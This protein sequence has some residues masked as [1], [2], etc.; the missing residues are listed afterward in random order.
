MTQIPANLLVPGQYEEIDN[1]LA[2][3]Q[4]DIK[5][6]LIMAYK[7]AAAPALAGKPVQVLTK[8]RAAELCGHGSP[9]AIMA[10]AFLSGNKTEESWILP[11]AE[12]EAGTKWQM[13]FTV[14]ASG[15]GNGSA[16]ITINGK[17]LAAAISAGTTAAQ[18]A[19]AIVARINSEENCPVEAA[20]DEGVVTVSSLVKGVWGNQNAVSITP[21]AAGVTITP[22]EA[23]PG[24]GVADL[25]SLFP[26]L[27]GIRYNY[28]LSDFADFANIAALASELESR[29]S[30]TRQI[31]GRAFIALSGPAGSA[32]EE[33]SVI[34][35][36]EAV[37]SPH[38]VL[39]PRLDNA[40]LPGEWAARFAAP[41]IRRLAD[42]PAANTYD[43]QAGGL[44]AEAEIDFDTRQK[45]LEAGI[46]T[47]RLDPVGNVLIER[48]VTSYTE[49][50]DGG[51]DTSYLDVQVAETVD[52]VRTY[53]NAEAKKRFKSWKLASTEE[54]FG[55]GSKVMSP[56]VFRSFLADL[57]QT[58]FIQEKQWC[59]NF[60]AY[61]DSILVEVMAGNKTRLQ[62]QH[63]PVLIGQFL[64]GAGLLQ[65]S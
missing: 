54:N 32:T 42:D 22:G 19:A 14:A 30:A 24:T 65:F 59:Q 48:L 61:K 64:I 62:Y 3:A 53:I 35:Q 28:F 23:T 58:V 45:L 55:A 44:K 2:G 49:N 31:G 21:A 34:A 27:G 41:A 1:S 51:R 7:T 11:V 12:P 9:A 57:Y 8:A 29:Y 60:E 50:T 10:E 39:V 47:W 20:S 56:G 25:A 37:N 33:G 15:A 36:A 46:S 13:P 43:I 16:A 6:V 52:A 40:Q 4:G 17:T 5:T 18:I 38:I 63:Q 26:G